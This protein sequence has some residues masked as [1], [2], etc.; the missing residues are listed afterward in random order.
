MIYTDDH[1]NLLKER[2]GK[3]WRPS[4]GTEGYLFMDAF[5]KN[6][7]KDKDNNCQIIWLSM[8]FNT[9]DDEYP[10]QWQY[11]EDGQ[12]TCTEFELDGGN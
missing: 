2:A 11:S 5:C 10:I 4:N 1:A 8:R 9:N 12:P 3:K 7:T 6:C